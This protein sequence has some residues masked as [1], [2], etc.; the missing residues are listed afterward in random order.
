[1]ILIDGKYI[2]GSDGIVYIQNGEIAW[3]YYVDWFR[4]DPE[5]FRT[6]VGSN[7]KMTAIAAVTP[8]YSM[9]GLPI[10]GSGGYG[11]AKYIEKAA[12]GPTSKVTITN[13]AKGTGN[14]KPQGLMDELATSGVK[15]NPNDVVAVTKTPDGKLVWLENGNSQAGLNHI[16]KHADEFA[17]KGISQNQLPEFITKAVSA[18]KIVGYQGKGTGR[19]IYEINF[20]GQTQRVAIT[21]GSN[22]FIVGANPVSVP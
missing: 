14:L 20:N 18:G 12:T 19:P 11:S 9:G 13:Q 6:M 7:D 15:Y 16:L 2:A 21:T 4:S 3:D 1:M 22:G 8:I 5:G 10:A 17:T